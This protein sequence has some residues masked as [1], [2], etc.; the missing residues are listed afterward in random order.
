MKGKK[1]KHWTSCV[2]FVV[3]LLLAA[4]VI[5]LYQQE[6]LQETYAAE[7]VRF[8]VL[9]NSD[10]DADQALKLQVRDAVGSYVSSILVNVSSREQTLDCIRDHL[11]E[12][13]AVAEEEIRRQGYSY[14]VSAAIEQVDFPEKSY[15]IYS[16]PEG[17]YTSLQ[18][19]IGAG[20]GANWWCVMYPNMC[21]RNS[22]YE[23]TEQEDPQLYRVFT[24]Y[25]YRQL[26][27]SSH[28]EVRLRL[29][30][31]EAF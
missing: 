8:H 16:L 1:M 27:E 4:G 6:H 18:V 21:F 3:S 9:A 7:V 10:S 14:S 28:K 22:T 11:E 29:L 30:D 15:G 13:E 23:V 20:A 19:E 24:L 17:S 31:A 12:I 5:L 2:K 26:I 25:E